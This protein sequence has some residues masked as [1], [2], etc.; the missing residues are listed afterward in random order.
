MTPVELSLALV[1]GLPSFLSACGLPMAPTDAHRFVSLD[2][3]EKEAS[4]GRS[5]ARSHVAATC[6][7]GARS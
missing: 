4:H 2:D 6:A 5:M 7:T 1:A 3:K